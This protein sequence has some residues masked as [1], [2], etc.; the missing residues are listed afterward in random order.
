MLICRSQNQ[1]RVRCWILIRSF[2]YETPQQ[3]AVAFL[4]C[5]V[6]PKSVTSYHLSLALCCALLVLP[7]DLGGS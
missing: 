6:N 4:E 2:G 3:E 5:F 1:I 7:T